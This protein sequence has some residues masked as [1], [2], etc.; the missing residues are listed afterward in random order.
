[1]VKP[2]PDWR[3]GSAVVALAFGCG[4]SCIRCGAILI[5]TWHGFGSAALKMHG[6]EAS[7][8]E[9]WGSVF[10]IGGAP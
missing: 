2:S 6:S 3:A 1:M 7:L 9:W 10:E 8:V 4:G 5:S